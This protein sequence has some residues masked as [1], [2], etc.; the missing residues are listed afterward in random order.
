MLYIGGLFNSLSKLIFKKVHYNFIY[1][2]GDVNN[3]VRRWP[4][5]ID[6]QK[7][8]LNP[9]C[10]VLYVRWN[11]TNFWRWS[12]KLISTINIFKIF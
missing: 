5:K 10:F 11:Q 12:I 2:I 4:E 6:H 3:L 9:C 8:E 7:S 1:L